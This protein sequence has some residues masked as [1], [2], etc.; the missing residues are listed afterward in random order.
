MLDRIELGAQR[1]VDHAAA[2]LDDEPA[3]DGG[4]DSDIEFDVLAADGFERVREASTCSSLSCSATVT[5][6]VTSPLCRA[7]S[8]RKAL[9][10]SRTANSR[11]L[12]VTT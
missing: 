4:I 5:S 7:T 11:R 6:A 10:I 2:E 8:A 3:D 12:A 1:T 9:I